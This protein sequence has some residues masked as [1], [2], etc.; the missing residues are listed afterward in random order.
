MSPREEANRLRALPLPSRV[1]L[2]F[3]GL[4][5]GA[6]GL[7]IVLG[8]EGPGTTIPYLWGPS[9][10]LAWALTYPLHASVGSSQ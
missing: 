2:A 3:G 10:A 8:Y 6:G 7:G 4:V 1:L 5:S 9:V